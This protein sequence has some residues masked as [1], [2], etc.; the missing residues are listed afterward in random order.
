MVIVKYSHRMVI[1]EANEG[2][3]ETDGGKE[4][5]LKAI[6]SIIKWRRSHQ[7]HKL[8]RMINDSFFTFF[9]SSIENSGTSHRIV[10]AISIFIDDSPEIVFIYLLILFLSRVCACFLRLMLL[11]CLDSLCARVNDLYKWICPDR[12]QITGY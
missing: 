11:L 4:L 8:S 6:S 7:F 10:R 5:F 9:P 2:K 1:D 3:T 12:Q